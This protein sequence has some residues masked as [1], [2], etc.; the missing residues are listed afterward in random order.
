MVKEVTMYMSMSFTIITTFVYLHKRKN[1]MQCISITQR[2]GKVY[3]FNVCDCHYEDVADRIWSYVRGYALRTQ[4]GYMHR[5][6][7]ELVHGPLKKGQR[8]IHKDGNKM[9]NQCYNLGTTKDLGPLRINKTY[10]NLYRIVY[11]MK[12]G[13]RRTI[14]VVESRVE[15]EDIIVTLNKIKNITFKE[16]KET[17]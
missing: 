11:L 2:S 13:K 16:A 5:I 8:V 9:N 1:V 15:A 4:E 17:V 14:K 7:Y 6:I 3:Q 12:N 10:N